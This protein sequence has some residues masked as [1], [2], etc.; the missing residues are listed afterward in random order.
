MED[1]RAGC[2]RQ[3]PN[4]ELGLETRSSS[5]Q[6]LWQ[7]KEVMAKKL[8]SPCCWPLSQAGQGSRT[9]RSALSKSRL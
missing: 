6:E 8:R 5:S 7:G 1:R 4:P 9:E 3:H 2:T